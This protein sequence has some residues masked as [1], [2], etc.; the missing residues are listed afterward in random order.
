ML[1]PAFFTLALA[2]VLTA[3]GAPPA[4]DSTEAPAEEAAT[5]APA[6]EAMVQP[7]WD[8]LDRVQD[9]CGMGT[10]RGFLGRLASEI[11]E[12]R[13]PPRVRILAPN[14]QATL[15]FV[16]S[17]LNILTDENGT[18]LALKCG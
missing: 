1:K 11:P 12:D 10:V 17:R 6:D 3:C 14:D 9:T 4:S 5:D 7:E 15:D 13:L 18:A 2:M 8:A 16:P